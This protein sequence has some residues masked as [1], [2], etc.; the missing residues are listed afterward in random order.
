MPWSPRRGPVPN[1]YGDAYWQVECLNRATHGYG[2]AT[3]SRLRRT[4]PHPEG[5]HPMLWLIVLILV[6]LAIAGGLALSK[7]IFLLLLVAI[8]VALLARRA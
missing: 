5:T 2:V 3:K 8:V 7:F 1:A 4:I 6:I